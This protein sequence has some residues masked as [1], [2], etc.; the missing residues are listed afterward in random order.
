M[1]HIP[2]VLYFL[3]VVPLCGSA[4]A[5][6][7]TVPASS[8]VRT[9]YT[10]NREYSLEQREL[11]VGAYEVVA[12]PVGQSY[13]LLFSID[14]QAGPPLQLPAVIRQ[15]DQVR[16]LSDGLVGIVGSISSTASAVLIVDPSSSSALDLFY[17]FHPNVSPDGRWIAFQQFFPAHSGEVHPIRIRL[18][19]VATRPH[20]RRDVPGK[21]ELAEVGVPLL[22]ENP[23]SDELDGLHDDESNVRLWSSEFAWNAVGTRLAFV[24][25]S[26]NG[27]RAYVASFTGACWA[28]RSAQFQ[29]DRGI[30]GDALALNCSIRDLRINDDDL[31]FAV[32]RAQREGVS[33]HSIAL[34]DFSP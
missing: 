19:D 24:M 9:K 1:N 10:L 21:G 18:Y 6:T 7:D 30:C 26:R 23:R 32:V 13:E 16:L 11:S 14:G 28:L 25:T 12:R 3:A 8:A 4:A 33:S 15:I 17:G 34:A 31:S 5:G 29:T 2:F 27:H 22:P 20:A